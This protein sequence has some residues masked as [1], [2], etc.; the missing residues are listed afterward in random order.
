MSVHLLSF[1]LSTAGTPSAASRALTTAALGLGGLDSIFDVSPTIRE[2]ALATDPPKYSPMLSLLSSFAIVSLDFLDLV[3]RKDRWPSPFSEL[4]R[5]FLSTQ[6]SELQIHPRG[7]HLWWLRYRRRKW[8][9]LQAERGAYA[10][11]VDRLSEL[12]GGEL[13]EN[14][15]KVWS[16]VTWLSEPSSFWQDLDWRAAIRT[17]TVFTS[18]VKLI[19]QCGMAGST[20][21][22]IC[23]LC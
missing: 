7:L 23:R 22:R 6:L 13:N 21:K 8:S 11:L 3:C 12:M 17:W 1:S 5:Y 9:R 10:L 15:R 4:D 14:L 16:P 2:A 19:H 20:R 18:M